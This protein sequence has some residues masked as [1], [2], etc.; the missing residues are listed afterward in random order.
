MGAGQG[1]GLSRGFQRG[2]EQLEA[3]QSHAGPGVERAY[4]PVDLF[5]RHAL[6]INDAVLALELAADRDALGI[7]RRDS[8]GFAQGFDE[9]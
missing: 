7:L 5:G 9:E 1:R 8:E 2:L 3:I 4:L 6:R